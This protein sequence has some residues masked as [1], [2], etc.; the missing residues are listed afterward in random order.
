S[1]T[2]TVQFA[3]TDGGPRTATLHIPSNDPDLSSL[4]VV[5]T[6]TGEEP[7]TDIATSSAALKFNFK[8][9]LDKL[10]LA[11]PLTLPAG[12]APEGKTISVTIGG[13]ANTQ[14]LTDKGKTVTDKENVFRLTGKMKNG[15]FTGA[16][17]VLHL[18]MKQ[19]DLFDALSGFGFTDATVSAKPPQAIP[20]D[21]QVM[22]DGQE[23]L[24]HPVFDY[25][26]KAGVSGTGK[27][28]K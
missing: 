7:A 21:V 12:F 8:K 3:P 27:L 16:P 14:T 2:F 1:T 19:Q 17:L 24:A 13:Y 25:S 20:V 18:L 26:A 11:A 23:Y 15:T 10:T 5:L 9:H 22:I 28:E 4:D 6:G